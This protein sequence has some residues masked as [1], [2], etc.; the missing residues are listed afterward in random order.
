MLRLMFRSV[1]AYLSATLAN[2]FLGMCGR[3]SRLDLD[4]GAAPEFDAPVPRLSAGRPQLR[5]IE[6]GKNRTQDSPAPEVRAQAS[7]LQ[8]R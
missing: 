8:R 5:V 3:A 6:G 4:S 7:Q 1:R 2:R